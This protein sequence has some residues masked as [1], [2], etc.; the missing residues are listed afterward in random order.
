MPSLKVACV[1][2]MNARSSMPSSRWKVC[3]EGMVASPTPTVPISSDSISWM[4]SS[5]PRL[6][7]S[8]AATIQP[9]VPPP[10]MTTRR[11]GASANAPALIGSG[12]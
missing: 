1:A 12:S 9:A 2:A 5:G 8:P 10:A 6:L 11:T 7:D 3:S 4:S